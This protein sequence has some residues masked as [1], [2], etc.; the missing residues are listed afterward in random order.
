MFF[1]LQKPFNLFKK[2]FALFQKMYQFMMLFS[3]QG[4]IRLQK[5]FHAIPDK[6]K[7]KISRDIVNNVL[8]RKPKMSNFVD[9][10][11]MK[12]GVIFL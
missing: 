1:N 6:E 2:F 8:Q 9:F 5:W 12:K 7:K 3:R 10:M 4:K 11:G